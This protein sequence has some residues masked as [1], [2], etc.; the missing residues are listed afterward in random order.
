MFRIPACMALT[1]AISFGQQDRKPDF[2]GLQDGYKDRD[3]DG[4]L[5]QTIAAGS[6]GREPHL[7]GLQHIKTF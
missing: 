1:I 3:P 6:Q 4:V 7:G 5:A 2:E